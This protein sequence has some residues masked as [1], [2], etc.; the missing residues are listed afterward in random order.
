MQV[1]E[2]INHTGRDLALRF[3]E[4]DVAEAGKEMVRR[5]LISPLLFTACA[6]R[7]WVTYYWYNAHLP[8]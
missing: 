8:L 7:T 4:S 3:V 1:G 2:L 5:E 6:V